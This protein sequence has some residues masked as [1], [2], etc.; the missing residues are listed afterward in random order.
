LDFVI[1]F[2]NL[3]CVLTYC[4]FYGLWIMILDFPNKAAFG[5]ST[6]SEQFVTFKLY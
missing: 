2:V 6:V 1:V 4:L 3:D 5:F